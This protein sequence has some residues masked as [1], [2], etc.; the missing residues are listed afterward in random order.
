M[1]LFDGNTRRIRHS[2]ASGS[3]GVCPLVAMIYSH[4][5]SDL[6]TPGSSLFM[7]IF[8]EFLA[9]F[10]VPHLPDSPQFGFDS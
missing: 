2:I 1:F 10:I 5:I 4:L 3:H 8:T 9:I 7:G 6:F